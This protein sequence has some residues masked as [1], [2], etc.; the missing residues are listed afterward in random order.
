MNRR[1]HVVRVGATVAALAALAGC[2]QQNGGA[3]AASSASQPAASAS[4]GSGASGAV[5]GTA[6]TSLGKVLTDSHGFTL[7]RFDPDTPTS[8][9]CTGECAA[10]WPPV[11]GMPSAASGTT[12]PGKLSTI[13]RPDG[14]T[15]AVYDGHPA[16]RYTQDRAPGQTNGEGVLGTWHVIKPDAGAAAGPSTTSAPSAAATTGSGSTSLY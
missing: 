1:T 3:S 2:A 12:L 4:S 11:T 7:Y 15:Q 5:F 9:A 13:S 16:Y 14:S 8:S 10:L 6:D